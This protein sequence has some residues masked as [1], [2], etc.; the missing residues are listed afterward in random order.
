V[1]QVQISSTLESAARLAAGDLVETILTFLPDRHGRVRAAVPP[2]E[3]PTN[4][5]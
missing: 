4:L 3:A 1:A 5:P 2:Q